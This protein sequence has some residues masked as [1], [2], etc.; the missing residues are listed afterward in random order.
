MTIPRSVSEVLSQHVTL[1]IEGIDRLYLNLYVPRLQRPE[2]VAHFWIYHRG[3]E[4]ASSSL[5]APMTEAFVSAIEKFAKAQDIDLVRF[6]KGQRKDDVT[7]LRSI[8]PGLRIRKAYC[9]SAR[10]KRRP[11]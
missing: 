11:R 8:W 6:E 5:M 3:H 10:L 4:F 1:E 7:R 9:S 2:G